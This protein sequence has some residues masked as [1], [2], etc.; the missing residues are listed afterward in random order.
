[1]ADMDDGVRSTAALGIKNRILTNEHDQGGARI[2][3]RQLYCL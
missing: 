3:K 1:M 2:N